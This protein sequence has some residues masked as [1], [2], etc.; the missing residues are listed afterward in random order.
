[1]IEVIESGIYNHW[2]TQRVFDTDDETLEKL[3]HIDNEIDWDSI[4]LTKLIGVYFMWAFGLFISIVILFFEILLY[5][6]VSI[7]NL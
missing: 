3:T 7:E 1:M 4:Y 2:L 6:C 5:F